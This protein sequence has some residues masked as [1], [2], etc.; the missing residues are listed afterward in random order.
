MIRP[1]VCASGV[2]PSFFQMLCAAALRA[3]GRWSV[4]RKQLSARRNTIEQGA[5]D[6]RTPEKEHDERI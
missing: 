2:D 6:T 1:A 4:N 3:T 5:Y